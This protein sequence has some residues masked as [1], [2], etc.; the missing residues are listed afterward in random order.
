MNQGGDGQF[1]YTLLTNHAR[2]TMVIYADLSIGEHRYSM[3][4]GYLLLLF[5]DAVAMAVP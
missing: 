5:I 4:N 1:L 2:D 3:W